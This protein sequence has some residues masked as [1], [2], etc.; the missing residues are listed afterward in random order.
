MF[1]LLIRPATTA[2]RA[3]LRQ[4]IVE[5]QEHERRLHCS[6]LPGEQIADA[7][8]AWIESQTMANGSLLVAEIEGR[9]AGWIEDDDAIAETQDSNRFAYVSDIFVA[10][11]YRGRGIAGRLLGAIERELARPGIARLRIATLAA[12]TSARRAYQRAEFS[13]YE[14]VYEKLIANIQ[15]SVREEAPADFEAIHDLTVAAFATTP[16]ADGDEA[17]FIRRQRA[18]KCYL[19]ALALAGEDGDAIVGHI[20]LTLADVG[21]PVPPSRTVLLAIVSVFPSAQRRGL[22]S[23]LVRE[24]LSRAKALGFRAVFVLGDPAFYRRF[25][26]E[27]AS[28]FS[29]ANSNGYPSENF[30]AL[31]LEYGALAGCDGVETLPP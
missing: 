2:D 21:G 1:G 31:E 26:F 17:D 29:I 28:I 6:R 24:A 14:I 13:K 11:L 30:M 10:S 22:G 19:P 20:M 5:L 18:G 27:S 12:N 15:L 23:R 25:G 4:A 8:L 3:H 7:Y 9:F 16:H